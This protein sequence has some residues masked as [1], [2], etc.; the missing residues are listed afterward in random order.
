MASK[1]GVHEDEYNSLKG[2]LSDVHGDIISQTEEILK[3]LESL[4]SSEGEF[5]TKSITPKVDMV[6]G[7][8]E[9][10]M[11]VITEIYSAHEEIID[12]FK[13]AIADL[14]TCC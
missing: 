3:M 5:Y 9:S 7:E 8:L 13:T 2:Q 10:A 6:C 4:N 14:D 12:S 1:I 11:S